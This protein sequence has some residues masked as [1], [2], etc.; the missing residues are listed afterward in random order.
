[1]KARL[2]GGEELIVG[3]CCERRAEGNL[4]PQQ[5]SREIKKKSTPLK[6]GLHGPCFCH[7]K[8]HYYLEPCSVCFG[9]G[10]GSS[11]LLLGVWVSECKRDGAATELD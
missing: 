3:G 10:D 6:I 4:L 1:M 8:S 11:V 9:R 7:L 2:G 5:M